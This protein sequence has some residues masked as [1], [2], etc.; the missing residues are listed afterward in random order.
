[1]I[2][3]REICYKTF[4]IGVLMYSHFDGDSPTRIYGRRELIFNSVARDIYVFQ[5]QCIGTKTHR[6]NVYWV[7]ATLFCVKAL[8]V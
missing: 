1:M 8:I 2:F 3:R 6:P 5:R 4:E 7:Q